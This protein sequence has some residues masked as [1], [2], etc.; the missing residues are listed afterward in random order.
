M[1]KNKKMR[2]FLGEWLEKSG[3]ITEVITF[4]KTEN[5]M[6]EK[7]KSC[8]PNGFDQFELTL[9][10]NQLSK[11][12]L[13]ALEYHS[14]GLSEEDCDQAIINGIRRMGLTK[15]KIT[16]AGYNPNIMNRGYFG[17]G[18]RKQ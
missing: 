18:G 11:A 16:A 3:K 13:L 6:F 4:K 5:T 17:T 2:G 12:N 14:R 9:I 10:R 1:K 7:V 15:E 8:H